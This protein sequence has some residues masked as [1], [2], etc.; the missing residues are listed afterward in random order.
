[1]KRIITVFVTLF[2][3][4]VHA[5]PNLA[6]CHGE[7]ALCAS[8][9]TEPTGKTMVVGSKTFEE[10]HAVCPVIKG[11]S[12]ADFNLTHGSC[13]PPKG[14]HTVWSLFGTPSTY[15]Q[16]PTWAPAPMT[17]RTFTTSV[18]VGNGMSNM[19]SFP[20]VKRPKKVN[21]ATLSDCFGPIN[22]SPWTGDHVLPGSNT[23]TGAPVGASDPVGG[24]FPSQ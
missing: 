12:V 22:E 4:A 1:M 6:I 17:V 16:S 15:P 21:G 18:G 23:G 10:G 5:D 19:W 24:N 20:C 2:S 7:Y 13:A 11:E 14:D 8:S 9:A 3:M